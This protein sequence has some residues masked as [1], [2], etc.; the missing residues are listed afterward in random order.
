MV[1][2]YSVYFEFFVCSCFKT[3][4]NLTFSYDRT[5]ILLMINAVSI[6]CVYFKT[7]NLEGT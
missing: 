6:L 5:T 2:F 4:K 3:D 1:T 7:N